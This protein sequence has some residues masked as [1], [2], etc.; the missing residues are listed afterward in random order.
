MQV[1]KDPLK[2]KGARLSMEL[3][4][5]GRYM[6]YAPTGE[7][8]GVSRR[9]EDSERER[10]RSQTAKLDLGGGGAIVRTAA[11]GAKRE[12][13]ERE[14]KYLHKLHE[15]LVKR[16]E[17]TQAPDLVFQEADLSVR[18]VRDIF[19][20][21]FERAIVDDEQQHHRLVSFFART[22]PELVERVELW[23]GQER[24][25]VRG[26]RRGQGDRRRDVPARG[27]AQRRLPDHRLRRGADR[28]RRQLRQL[29]RPRQRRGARG[30]DH[31]DQPRGR[32]GG[33]Q[34]AAPARHRRDHR[35]RLHRHG[36][37]AQPRRGHED[38]AQDARRGPHEDV[39]RRDLQ[40]RPG[41]DDPPERDRG[42]ARDHEPPVPDVRGRGRDPLGGDDRDR[43]R[44]P[45]ARRRRRAPRR[46]RRSS[47]R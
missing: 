18:V 22:A 17:D 1:V 47:C 8:I 3:T 26:L 13:F 10:L 36:A 31:Q 9:L 25:A 23:D 20:E 19:S 15:V 39:H 41:R 35:D 28:D 40:A 42:R 24:A 2:T 33:R 44:A 4:I 14:L 34:P 5:A 7:G 11:H 46:A 16:V 27:P 6:V 12:D 30:H 32:R 38:A 43:V 29:H 45:A 21:H 37:R